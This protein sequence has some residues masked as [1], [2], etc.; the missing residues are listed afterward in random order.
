MTFAPNHG[1]TSPSPAST[2]PALNTTSGALPPSLHLSSPRPVVRVRS[3]QLEQA[4]ATLGLG[5]VPESVY[6]VIHFFNKHPGIQGI[7]DWVY[8]LLEFSGCLLDPQGLM[9]RYE[10]LERWGSDETAGPYGR[11]WVN[12]WTITVPKQRGD[13]AGWRSPSP[14]PEEREEDLANAMHLSYMMA[15]SNQGYTQSP[16]S[17]ISTSDGSSIQSSLFHTRT[18][19]TSTTPSDITESS[20]RSEDLKAA[21]EGLHTQ[22]STASISK[23]EKTALKGKEKELKSEQ[24]ALEKEEKTLRKEAERQAKKE[25]K[26]RQRALDAAAKRARE[27]DKTGKPRHF[28]VLPRKGNDQRWICVP[29]AGADS[30]VSAHT[31][32][33]FRQDNLEYDRM[34]VDVGNLVRSFWDGDGGLRHS[35]SIA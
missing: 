22:M 2:P 21:L 4:F 29:I 30:E 17:T 34:V 20:R 27:A 16:K 10:K 8:Q 14:R 32:I 9:E 12:L 24:K 28:I 31:S 26:E 5:P 1:R 3:P 19:S 33:F 35:K 23:K 15:Q 13:T 25:S 11:G 18:A 6:N 7:K